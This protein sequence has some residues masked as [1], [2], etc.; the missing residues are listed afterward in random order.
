MCQKEK[1]TES[2]ML[3]IAI[4]VGL[5][6]YL[7]NKYVVIPRQEFN[8]VSKMIQDLVK[9]G[10]LELSADGKYAKIVKVVGEKI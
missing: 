8:D 2:R 9:M 1:N 5:I 7:T 10:Y 6:L 3:K 4:G